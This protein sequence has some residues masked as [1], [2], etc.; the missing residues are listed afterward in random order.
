[1]FQYFKGKLL[2]KII[3]GSSPYYAVDV[4]ATKELI[5]SDTFNNGN[6]CGAIT[7]GVT[8]VE[9]RIGAAPLT[10][11]KGVTIFH[12]SSGKMYYGCAAITTATGTQIFKNTQIFIPAGPNTHV[13]LISDTAAQNV[14]LIE[15]A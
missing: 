3:G 6:A 5:T 11:R 14:R 2:S 8:A 4:S 1:M 10:N 9:A 7:V 15:Y 12:N 13:Y